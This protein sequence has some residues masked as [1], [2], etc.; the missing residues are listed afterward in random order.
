MVLSRTKGAVF[1]SPQWL[2]EYLLQMQVL[3][4]GYRCACPAAVHL[5]SSCTVAVIRLDR[6]ILGMQFVHLVD[7][8][9]TICIMCRSSMS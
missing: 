6:C 1:A 2:L 5:A 3:M 8:D 4:L 9:V 7:V